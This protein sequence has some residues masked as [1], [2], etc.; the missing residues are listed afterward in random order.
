MKCKFFL[1]DNVLLENDIDNPAGFVELLEKV[2]NIKLCD[3]DGEYYLVELES[4]QLNQEQMDENEEMHLV[5]YLYF[6]E[7][8]CDKSN[9]E[10]L[11]N[12]EGRSM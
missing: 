8:K 1:H 12:K 10:I 11:D 2:T 7:W 9:K 4:S 6:K 5:L 3:N